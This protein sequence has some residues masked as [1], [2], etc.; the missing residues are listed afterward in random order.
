MNQT[1]PIGSA[2]PMPSGSTAGSQAS[3]DRASR[4]L[5]QS[6]DQY[7]AAAPLNQYPLHLIQRH[8]IV[9]PV[10]QPGGGRRFMIGGIVMLVMAARRG[11]IVPPLWKRPV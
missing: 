11:K 1:N 5:T 8:L 7:L 4:P 3:C 2:L 9:A 10:I 6:Q